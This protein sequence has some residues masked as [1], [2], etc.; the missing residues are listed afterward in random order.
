[1]QSCILETASRKQRGQ[2]EVAV[3]FVRRRFAKKR[4]V[5][6]LLFY[7]LGNRRVGETGVPKRTSCSNILNEVAMEFEVK[8]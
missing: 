8:V 5:M 4:T 3:A 1:M 2:W 7:G 6:Q